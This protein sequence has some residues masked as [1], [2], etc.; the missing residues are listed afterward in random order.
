M[1][2]E[3]FLQES[4]NAI[5]NL[6]ENNDKISEMINLLQEVRNNKKNVFVIGNGGSSSTASH[7]VCDLLKTSI[8]NSQPRFRAQCLSDNTAVMTAWSND[9]SY[10]DIF[11]EQLKNFVEE[12]DILI[13]IS[14]SGNST[15]VIKAVE[16]SKRRGIKTIGLTGNA[17]KLEQLSDL[18]IKVPSDNILLI[19]GVHSVLLHYITEILRG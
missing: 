18:V 14:C 5:D 10:D 2:N 7:F 1:E 8:N 3:K 17:G 19:E 12:G 4:K 11:S 15:N 13:A 6:I 9:V 16:E